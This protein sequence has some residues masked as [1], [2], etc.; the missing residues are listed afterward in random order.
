M[1]L[2]GPKPR[3]DYEKWLRGNPGHVVG[4]RYPE[5]LPTEAEIMAKSSETSPL[6]WLG[7]HNDFVADPPRPRRKSRRARSAGD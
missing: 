5:E 7:R 1:G 2:R 3:S 4:L 6:G